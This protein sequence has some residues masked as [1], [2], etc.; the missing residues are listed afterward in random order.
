MYPH[1]LLISYSRLLVKEQVLRDPRSKFL[2]EDKLEEVF[3]WIDQIP[4]EK[5]VKV[6]SGRVV[7]AD[8][9]W[10]FLKK[11]RKKRKGYLP[12]V[13]ERIKQILHVGLIAACAMLPIGGT[14]LYLTT[15]YLV[16]AYNYECEAKCRIRNKKFKDKRFCYHKCNV[17]SI[18]K[19]INKIKSEMPSCKHTDNPTRCENNMYEL[20]GKWEKKWV[21]AKIK[22][23]NHEDKRKEQQRKT[24]RITSKNNVMGKYLGGLHK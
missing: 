24:T 15:M 3:E 1:W 2:P 23:Q 6:A 21:K 8:G 13:G 17:E 11:R 16:E 10:A 22:L 4:P 20:L 7:I 12:T 5:L 14:E 19:M 9:G 18:E